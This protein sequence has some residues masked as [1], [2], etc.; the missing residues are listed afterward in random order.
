MLP[1]KPKDQVSAAT[2]SSSSDPTDKKL[3]RLRKKLA[4]IEALKSRQEKGEK[5]E[6]TQVRP[7]MFR[8]GGD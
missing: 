3:S 5:L 2:V 1:S 8:E 7:L 6:A 4:Q